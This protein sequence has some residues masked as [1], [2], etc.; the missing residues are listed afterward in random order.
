MDVLGLISLFICIISIIIGFVKPKTTAYFVLITTPI[1]SPGRLVLVPS[2]TL[3]LEY[4]IFAFSLSLGIS[5]S[6]SFRNLI[7]RISFKE[8]RWVLVVVFMLTLLIISSNVENIPT[9]LF[10]D[11]T[12]YFVGIIIPFYLVKNYSDLELLIK[13]LVIQG[14]LVGIFA[15][16]A[17]LDIF[18]I[19]YW[20][21]LTVPDYNLDIIRDVERVGMKRIHGLDGSASQTA[22]RLAFLFF[23]SLWLS[24][25][26]NRLR[27][28]LPLLLII[29]GITLLQTRAA[30]VA[31]FIGFIYLF[32]VLSQKRLLST[33][34]IWVIIVS[35]FLLVVMLTFIPFLRDMLITFVG[36]YLLP[37]LTT[38]N[39]SIDVKVERIPIAFDYALNNLYFG[40]GSREY[41]YYVIMRTQDLPTPLI[42]LLSGGIFLMTSLLI[43]YIFPIYKVWRSK[44]LN[45]LN[46]EQKRLMIYISAALLAGFLMTLSNW[47]ETHRMIMV[48]TFIGAIKYISVAKQSYRGL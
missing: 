38:Q 45:Y 39:K 46:K 7:K 23:I 48:M 35:S 22:S 44:N 32:F 18:R 3:P 47:L 33:K 17:Y 43:V 24:V 10:L 26:K 19:T 14:A 15:L 40:Y 36:D 13:I 28:Y 12:T 9:V 5:L 29:V 27:Y 1:L 4:V 2:T 30:F 25:K 34:F 20:L 42:Y 31:V 6:P 8:F 41:V 16:L 37:S 11:L 21:R